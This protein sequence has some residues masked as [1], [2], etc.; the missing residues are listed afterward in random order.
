MYLLVVD[1]GVIISID[2]KLK[3]NSFFSNFGSICSVNFERLELAKKEYE[4]R[5]GYS[6]SGIDYINTPDDPVYNKIYHL[7]VCYRDKCEHRNQ[8]INDRIKQIGEIDLKQMAYVLYL[9]AKN[10]K[11]KGFPKYLTEER[12]LRE[13]VKESQDLRR[14]FKKIR[15]I[16]EKL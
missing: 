4:D 1:N 6:I 11:S 2:E 12:I 10:I 9:I 3:W 5:K 7:L 14:Y 15:N 13:F 8:H 16:F